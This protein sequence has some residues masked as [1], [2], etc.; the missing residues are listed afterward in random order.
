MLLRP[1]QRQI[2]MPV[3]SFTKVRRLSL[4]MKNFHPEILTFFILWLSFIHSMQANQPN[5]VRQTNLS[6]WVSPTPSAQE[7][8]RLREAAMKRSHRYHPV[9]V[10]SLLIAERFSHTDRAPN[11][12][13]SVSSVTGTCAFDQCKKWLCPWG[14]ERVDETHRPELPTAP[15]HLRNSEFYEDK[16]WHWHLDVVKSLIDD[17]T[18]QFDR[19]FLCEPMSFEWLENLYKHPVEE[20]HILYD[21]I[22]KSLNDGLPLQAVSDIARCETLR[23]IECENIEIQQRHTHIMTR[24]RNMEAFIGIANPDG[25]I[26]QVHFYETL[27]NLTYI[28][29]FSPWEVP[30]DAEYEA[31]TDLIRA[32]RD[33]LEHIEFVLPP[34]S[35]LLAALTHCPKLRS[36]RL[37]AFA[38]IVDSDLKAF[39]S[40]PNIRQNI[41]DIWLGYT[42]IGAGTFALLAKMRN[43]RW[44]N[45]SNTALTGDELNAI[46]RANK[47]HIRSVH[48]G[49]RP[50]AFSESTPLSSIGRFSH[51]T[52]RFRSMHCMALSLGRRIRRR[53]TQ[54]WDPKR[55]AVSS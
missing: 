45:L 22:P 20:I 38:P 37:Q 24:M 41:R 8:H 19:I 40:H 17:E 46:L 50:V 10:E 51:R 5:I 31:M 52:V 11:F 21:G 34:R 35:K 27:P 36:F 33:T 39:L 14:V 4:K 29:F 32:R 1:C 48:A 6:H 54:G 28:H 47:E 18:H 42:Q 53:G 3:Q 2:S 26:N 9:L 55:S 12:L 15:A 23:V 43:L 16:N 7:T 30:T 49:R 13:L 44:I 25:I